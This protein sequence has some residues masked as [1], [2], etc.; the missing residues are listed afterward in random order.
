M[1]VLFGFGKRTT[2]ELGET[3][4]I[5]C[6]RC[7]NVR[8]WQYKKYTTWFTLFFVPV[9]PYQNQYVKECPICKAALKVDKD[10]A[11]GKIESIDGGIPETDGLTEVQRNYRK[12]MEDFKKSK[13]D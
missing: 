4:K 9:I 7:G 2:K 6:G 1:F 11:S 5:R 10:E 8:P 3:S 12:Q 13:E